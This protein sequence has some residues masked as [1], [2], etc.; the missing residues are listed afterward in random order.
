[1]V[2]RHS[3]PFIAMPA[4]R[5]E[6]AMRGRFTARSREPARMRCAGPARRSRTGIVGTRIR[7]KNRALC[8]KNSSLPS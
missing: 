2:H 5:R 8:V 4:I 3:D 6:C 7:A 1:M